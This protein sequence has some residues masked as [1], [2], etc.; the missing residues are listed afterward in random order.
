MEPRE[1][2]V[3]GRP[4]QILHPPASNGGAGHWL[5]T[6]SQTRATGGRCEMVLQKGGAVANGSEDAARATAEAAS[7]TPTFSQSMQTGVDAFRQSDFDTAVDAFTAAHTLEPTLPIPPYNMA[8]C[9]A[10][11]GAAPT[12]VSWLRTALAMQ[13]MLDD[14]VGAGVAPGEQARRAGSAEPIMA[15][16]L[17]EVLDDPDFDGIH[18]HPLF[19]ALLREETAKPDPA[20]VAKVEAKAGWKKVK[21]VGKREKA[22]KQKATGEAASFMDVAGLCKAEVDA[23]VATR[24]AAAATLKEEKRKAAR[25]RIAQE[26]KRAREDRRKTREAEGEKEALKTLALT[27]V[28]ES[29]GAKTMNFALKTRSFVSKHT[30]KRESL[31][32]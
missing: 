25:V 14:G 26:R 32:E 27:K 10:K 24:Q 1:P 16:G 21:V 20:A 4:E 22:K 8:C 12:S 11:L 29:A 5:T 7:L 2:L 28:L 3:E 17:T 9:H 19:E 6:E 30:Q 31:Y 23:E 13:R 18:S 15:I